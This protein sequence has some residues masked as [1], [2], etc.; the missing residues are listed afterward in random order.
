MQNRN[1]FMLLTKMD[2]LG[3][4]HTERV[5]PKRNLLRAHS[6]D[7]KMKVIWLKKPCTNASRKGTKKGKLQT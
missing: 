2:L 5:K 6:L 3:L 7:R 4:K 1:E